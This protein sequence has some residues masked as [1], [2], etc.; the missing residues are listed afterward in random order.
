M[1]QFNGACF[2]GSSNCRPCRPA[3]KPL[4]G[5]GRQAELGRFG[6]CCWPQFGPSFCGSQSRAGRSHPR[7]RAAT[8]RCSLR[9]R[10]L[11]LHKV[12]LYYSQ[13]L[14]AACP[15]LFREATQRETVATT[16]CAVGCKP[17]CIETQ[18]C[19]TVAISRIIGRGRPAVSA[20]A[21]ARQIARR[22]IHA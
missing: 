10:W 14:R 21:D 2:C 17:R 19:P 9:L 7:R 6:L 13:C 20:V 8:S 22:T 18:I 3:A 5:G 11:R 15:R 16:T 1:G 12:Q 4:G